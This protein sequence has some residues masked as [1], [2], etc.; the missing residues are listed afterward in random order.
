MSWTWLIGWLPFFIAHIFKF[1]SPTSPF[2]NQAITT[3]STTL[4]QLPSFLSN[5]K[6]PQTSQDSVSFIHVIS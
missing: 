2:A 3:N 5:I 6:L 1:I 4:L